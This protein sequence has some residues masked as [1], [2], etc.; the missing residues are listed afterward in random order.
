LALEP[1]L[2][3]LH[4]RRGQKERSTALMRNPHPPATRLRVALVL[5]LSD[6]LLAFAMW[7]VAFVL[8]SV[9]G[10]GALS[11]ISILSECV[12]SVVA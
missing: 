10:R 9:V 4:S 3:T 11:A 7:Q 12:P 8:N 6:A 2:S 1:L 5:I